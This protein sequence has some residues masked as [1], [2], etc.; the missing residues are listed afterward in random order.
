[1]TTVEV[2]SEKNDPSHPPTTTDWEVIFWIV[3]WVAAGAYVM[4]LYR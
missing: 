3:A 1:M 2:E 4:W